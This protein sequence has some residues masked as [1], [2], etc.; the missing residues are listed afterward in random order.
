MLVDR[1]AKPVIESTTSLRMNGVNLLSVN[2]VNLLSLI[3]HNSYL[4]DSSVF[5]RGLFD[6]FEASNVA[7]R[8]D[9]CHWK[10]LIDVI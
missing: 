1:I 8:N 5:N 3:S 4:T 2:G 9:A 10:V 7:G 6:F